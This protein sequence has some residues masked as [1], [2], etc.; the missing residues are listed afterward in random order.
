MTKLKYEQIADNLRERISAGEFSSGDR[1]PSSREL[2]EQWNVS[3]ATAIKAMEQLRT[4]GVVEARQG[5]GFTVIETPLA[6]PAGNRQAGTARVS[7]RPYRRL[8]VPGMRK[9]PSQVAEALALPDGEQA[10]H[11][12]RLVLADDGE[13]YSYVTAWFPPDV[14]EACPRLHQDGPLTEGTTRYVERV[15]HRAPAHGVDT[16]TVR[17]GTDDEAHHLGVDHLSVVAV[18]VHTAYDASGA[19][20]VC[21]VGVTPGP[22]WERVDSYSMGGSN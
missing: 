13:P 14:A 10:L 5:S 3:R 6:R 15:T 1:L 9:P 18:V 7:G 12:A 2:C 22:L 21:E 20:L 19:P 11:R 4:D 8:G 16:T 17:L